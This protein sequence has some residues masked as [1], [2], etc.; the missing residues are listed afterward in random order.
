MSAQSIFEAW[1]RSRAW[2]LPALEDATEDE[3]LNEL[4]TGRAMIWPGEGGAVVTRCFAEPPTLHIWLAG[5]RLDAV[6][7]LLPGGTAW[8]R[9]MGLKELTVKGRR[10]WTRIL[11]R[12]GF[13]GD[14]VMRKAI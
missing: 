14:D 13:E 10:G 6:M 7:A 4:L 3:V 1:N 11:S 2:L 5:G 8:G 12:F 9:A